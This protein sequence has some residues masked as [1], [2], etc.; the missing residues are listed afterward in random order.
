MNFKQ[1]KQKIRRSDSESNNQLHW[2]SSKISSYVSY[3]AFKLGLSA[4]QM[5][6]VFFIFG[7]AS[8]IFFISNS[9]I[10]TILGYLLF[11]MHIICDMSDGDLARINNSYSI[12]GVYWD[13]MAHSII[14]PLI[15]IAI[16]Y[17]LYIKYDEYIFL[18]IMTIMALTISLTSAV[19]NN[20]YKALYFYN[21]KK[22]KQKVLNLNNGIKGK[23]FFIISES[24]SME[25][26][27]LF[28]LIEVSVP[29]SEKII[30][31]SII[32]YIIG[33]LMVIL[34]KLYQNSYKDGSISKV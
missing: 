17:S 32:L 7:I 6:V 14:N 31:I 24:L 13:S 20:Y 27:I 22:N 10:Y 26:L 4:D 16:S 34:I 11:R 28:K 5:T 25:G 2:F 29:L 8:S 30:L 23:I 3:F 1:F 9:I 12:R 15:G 18:I 19:K 33:N 21:S